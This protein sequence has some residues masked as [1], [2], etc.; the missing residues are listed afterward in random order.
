MKLYTKTGDKGQTGLAN[1]MRLSKTSLRVAAYGDVDEL[2]SFIGLARCHCDDKQ[3]N[4]LLEDIQRDLFLLEAHLSQ[5]QGIE[6]LRDVHVE[7]LE[8]AIDATWEKMK[9]LTNFILPAGA[10]YA[11]LMHVCR[12][13]C[14]RAERSVITLTEKEKIDDNLV[15]YLNRLSDL[16]FAL[17][18]KANQD[19]GIEDAI[20]K[21]SQK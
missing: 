7:K 19:A 8:K 4:A 12:T 9:P 6:P 21:H 15:I 13:V 20:W 11:A 17:A 1:G 10:E 3:E 5:A 2:N 18:R 16:F 14:R